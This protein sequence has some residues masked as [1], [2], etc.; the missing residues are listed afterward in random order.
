MFISQVLSILISF[1]LSP[2]AFEAYIT[3]GLI[4]VQ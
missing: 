4:I 2:Y 3:T 1:S